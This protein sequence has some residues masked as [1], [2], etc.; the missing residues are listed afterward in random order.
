[1]IKFGDRFFLTPAVKDGDW[2]SL[3]DYL[4]RGFE[5]T[6]AIRKFLVRVLRDEVRRPKHRPRQG[7]TV[8]KQLPVAAFA[9]ALKAGGA[10]DYIEQTVDALGIEPEVVKRAVKSWRKIDPNGDQVDW[11]LDAT[12]AKLSPGALKRLAPYLGRD[13]TRGRTERGSTWAVEVI[14]KEPRQ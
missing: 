11:V 12:K 8:A 1:M 5:V 2:Q 10:R 9:L 6:P 14:K 4:E 13:R 3:A 7:R